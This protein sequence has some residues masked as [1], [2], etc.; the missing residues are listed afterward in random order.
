MFKISMNEKFNFDSDSVGF[1]DLA[2]ALKRNID[3]QMAEGN[4]FVYHR[5]GSYFDFILN[6]GS[7]RWFN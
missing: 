1:W 2:R 7:L 4:H 5:H 3:M 6:G